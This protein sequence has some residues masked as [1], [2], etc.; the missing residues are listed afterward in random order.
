M[1]LQETKRLQV[2]TLLDADLKHENNASMVGVSVTTLERV[3]KAKREGKDMKRKERSRKH[4][5]ARN[6]DFIDELMSRLASDPTKSIRQDAREFGCG[7][8]TVSRALKWSGIKS[9]VSDN[10]N[11]KVL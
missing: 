11:G 1:T 7:R 3:T 6:E 10:R 2:L 5:S 8:D 9:F 4:C